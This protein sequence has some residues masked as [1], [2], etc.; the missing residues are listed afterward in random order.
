MRRLAVSCL[1]SF[2]CA[3]VGLLGCV[4]DDPAALFLDLDYQVRCLD[5]EPRSNDEPA[6][7]IHAVDG[8]DDLTINCS[9]ELRDGDRLVTISLEHVDPEDGDVDYSLSID[10]VNLDSKDPGS[11][12]RINAKEG[13][14]VYEGNC[15]GSEPSEDEP[16]VIKLEQEGD[17]VTGTLHCVRIPN[18]AQ[19]T[20]TRHIV[21]SG[22]EK[23]A[24]LE[25]TGCG[26]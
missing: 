9:T 11:G 20:L 22:S 2:S 6:R 5:C 26:L 12:C 4:E 7:K 23:A 25:A 3:S 14:N 15:S 10:Q 19:P 18:K 16:C 1:V 21:A 24:K 13:P 17:G 8:E